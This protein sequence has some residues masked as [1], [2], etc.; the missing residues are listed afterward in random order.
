LLF[1]FI[2]QKIF[3]QDTLLTNS[4]AVGVFDAQ[5]SFYFA[6][7]DGNLTK[8]PLFGK[9]LYY[10]PTQKIR[11]SSLDVTNPLRIFAFSAD[12]QKV[13]WF[14][15]FL[16]PLESY[17]LENQDIGLVRLAAPSADQ[18]LWIYEENTQNLLKCNLLQNQVLFRINIGALLES[19]DF[20][21]D[22]LAEYQ[23]FI[24]LHD[25]VLGLY[26]LDNFGNLK[27]HFQTNSPKNIGFLENQIYFLEETALVFYDFYTQKVSK[28]EIGE[29][30][31][32]YFESKTLE[33][34]FKKRQ[35]LF[36]K[37]AK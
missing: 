32:A 3:S 37:K 34:F 28:K 7:W 9:E 29:E 30:I 16:R 14:D 10:S 36:F 31:E 24:F 8:K 35:L 4:L 11:V 26:I 25:P 23:D 21:P 33:I 15:R 27:T 6:D 5:E 18:T 13:Y 19:E 20:L 1:F 12:Q 22:F 17:L 2:S